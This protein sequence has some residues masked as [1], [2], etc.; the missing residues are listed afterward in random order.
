MQFN[1]QKG[2]HKKHKWNGSQEATKIEKK[3]FDIV[4]INVSRVFSKNITKETLKSLVDFDFLFGAEHQHLFGFQSLT[5]VWGSN[6]EF[7]LKSKTKHQPLGGRVAVA[8]DFKK[9]PL[10]RISFQLFK[11]EPRFTLG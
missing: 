1:E 2:V 5:S 11:G 3:I 4:Q 6:D 10:Y 9:N 7:R 8:C